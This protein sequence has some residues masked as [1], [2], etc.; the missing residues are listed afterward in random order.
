M[1]GGGALSL[2]TA[3]GPFSP[4]T[5]SPHPLHLTQAAGPCVWVLQWAVGRPR[6]RNRPRYCRGV[7]CPHLTV[8]AVFPSCPRYLPFD[9]LLLLSLFEVRFPTLLLLSQK[10][11]PATSLALPSQ[12]SWGL[13]LLPPSS[14]VPLDFQVLPRATSQ[15]G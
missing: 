2:C 13:S 7:S 3:S 8:A 10:P 14:L 15:A 5:I 11:S 12:P 1:G 6:G 4:Y 9:F